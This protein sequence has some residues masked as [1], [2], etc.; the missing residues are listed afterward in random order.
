VNKKIKLATVLFYSLKGLVILSLGTVSRL[1]D[2]HGGD[3]LQLVGWVILGVCLVFVVYF[4]MSGD[5]LD[6]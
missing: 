5:K 3:T 4:L 2:Y 1:F 6:S